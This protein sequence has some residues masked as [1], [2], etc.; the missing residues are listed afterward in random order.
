MQRRSNSKLYKE[1]VI[2]FQSIPIKLEPSDI[3]E[4]PKPQRVIITPKPKPKIKRFKAEKLLSN[5]ETIEHETNSND[6]ILED[7]LGN[8]DMEQ[9]YLQEISDSEIEPDMKPDAFQEFKMDD[10]QDDLTEEN[11]ISEFDLFGKS[12]ALQ[13]NHMEVS[14][15]ISFFVVSYLI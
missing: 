15:K 4:E 10:M 6:S 5:T 12:V 14:Y 3:K 13:L 2:C 7:L 8:E 9:Q 1:M 11:I